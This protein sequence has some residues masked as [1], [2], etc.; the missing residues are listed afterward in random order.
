MASRNELGRRAPALAGDCEPLWLLHTE[1]EYISFLVNLESEERSLRHLLTCSTC[2]DTLSKI[3]TGEREPIDELERLFSQDLPAR[4]GNG[5]G[6][7]EMRDFSQAGAFIDAR[8]GWRLER[9]RK[10]RTDAEL[11]LGQ[12]SEKIRKQG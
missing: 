8:V 12:L 5:Y 7:P 10:L 1:S 11:E 2:R 9:L 3:F 6:C 4:L